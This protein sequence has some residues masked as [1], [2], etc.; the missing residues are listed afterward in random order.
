MKEVA[1]TDKVKVPVEAP[2]SAQRN[3]IRGQ[4]AMEAAL[5]TGSVPDWYSVEPLS[6]FPGEARAT[7]LPFLVEMIKDA[8]QADE[9][10]VSA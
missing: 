3:I 2:S 5:A 9:A 8:Q 1:I 10:P 4:L 6:G 7:F